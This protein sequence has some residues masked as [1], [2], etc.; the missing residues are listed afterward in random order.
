MMPLVLGNFRR[1]VH[2]GNTIGR[3]FDSDFVAKRKVN[4]NSSRWMG[5]NRCTW[6]WSQE[7]SGSLCRVDP[8]HLVVIGSRSSLV[9][10][11]DVLTSATFIPTCS[12]F[13]LTSC[14][15]YRTTAVLRTMTTFVVYHHFTGT[16]TAILI[17]IDPDYGTVIRTST[18]GNIASR[19]R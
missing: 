2:C 12:P 14:Q 9:A 15:V 3:I 10:N 19:N 11:T 1:T 16:K 18:K 13:V 17:H 5:D 4:T 7:H 6:I 8:G